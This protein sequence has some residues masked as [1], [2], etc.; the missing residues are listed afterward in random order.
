M[1]TESSRVCTYIDFYLQPLSTLHPSYIKNTYDFINKIRNQPVPLN[2][3]LITADVESLYTNM[4]LDLILKC[5][6]EAFLENPDPWRPD[7]HLLE[8]LKLTLYFNDFHFD[9]Q[10][11]LQVCGIAMGHRYAPSAANIYLKK[12]DDLATH[13]PLLNPLL[14]FRFLDDIFGVWPGTVAQL[15]ECESSLNTLIPACRCP[16]G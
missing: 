8:L 9:N 2:S 14:Y 4:K 15:K 11:F 10:F 3:V 1:D 13:T 7:I 12:F 5:I 6:Y 16:N